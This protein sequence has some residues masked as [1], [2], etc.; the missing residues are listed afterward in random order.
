MLQRQEQ[1]TSVAAAAAAT[2]SS[3]STNRLDPNSN[4]FNRL[5][6]SLES[7]ESINR[8]RTKCRKC[9]SG[10]SQLH[11]SQ[12]DMYGSRLSTRMQEGAR[13][14]WKA[15]KHFASSVITGR[16]SISACRK[17]QRRPA[18]SP[19]PARQAASSL[20]A[21]AGDLCASSELGDS[22]GQELTSVVQV[23]SHAQHNPED[24]QHAAGSPTPSNSDLM[25][26]VDEN[27]KLTIV[28]K[29]N[30]E[31][32]T[33]GEHSPGGAAPSSASSSG[34]DRSR[35]ES[36]SSGRGTASEAGSSEPSHDEEQMGAVAP[37]APIADQSDAGQDRKSKRTAKSRGKLFKASKLLGSGSQLSLNK[38]KTFLIDGRK[39]KLATSAKQTP[40]D[41]QPQ[42]DLQQT[43]LEG[44]RL[45]CLELNQAINVASM[46]ATSNCDS[47]AGEQPL[48]GTQEA[49]G[50]QG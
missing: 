25:V 8:L 19:V 14:A 32:A 23:S 12:Q 49:A 35:C 38:L 47:Q 10:S 7:N 36:S 28:T 5:K 20:P 17:H 37:V 16:V 2:N 46:A 34:S 43:D 45:R 4:Y 9:Q 50:V 26:R 40:D 42:A 15:S 30:N 27:N 6:P 39:Q 3:G 18:A 1:L 48:K 41:S 24:V 11:L 21:V 22:Q 31:A 29:F 44:A 13:S 33:S